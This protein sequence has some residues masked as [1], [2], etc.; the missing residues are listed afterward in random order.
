MIDDSQVWLNK[1]R[2]QGY[3][4][5]ALSCVGDSRDA[6]CTHLIICSKMLLDMT[7]SL[8]VFRNQA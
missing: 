1:M 5:L 2:T 3:E 7:P 4:V 8:R 6:H